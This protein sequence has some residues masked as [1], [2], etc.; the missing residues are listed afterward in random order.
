MTQFQ[1]RTRHRFP[2]A[3]SLGW[4]AVLLAL[5]LVLVACGGDD[6]GD[7]S[8]TAEATAA[9]TEPAETADD[10]AT[11]DGNRDEE[12]GADEDGAD[13]GEVPDAI[14]DLASDSGSATVTIGDET[15]EFSLAGTQTIDGTTY[16]G[17]CQSLFGIVLGSGF[18]ADG[19]DVTVDL[20]IPP[21]DWETYEDDRFD[22]PAVEVEDN[23]NNAKWV[24]DQGDEFAAGGGIGEY[25]QEDGT[26]SGSATFVNQWAPD[27]EPVEGSFEV[28]CAA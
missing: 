21:V 3:G 18:A 15:F 1:R 14:A 11:D 13:D 23:V 6:D 2:D 22:P 7:A 26:A 16:V 5:S 24:A 17:R 9:P 27:S 12:A 20:E 19:S 10:P 8:A 28:D 4:P 25:E